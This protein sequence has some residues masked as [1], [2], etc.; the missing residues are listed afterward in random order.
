[1]AEEMEKEATKEKEVV[2]MLEKINGRMED[3]TERIEEIGIE[4]YFDLLK[5]PRRLL[6]TNF[7]VGLAR[8]LGFAV[9]ATILGAIFLM[10]L[11]RL[12]ELNLPVI[13]EFIARVIRIV[14][15]FL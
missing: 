7:I 15:E 11:F 4:D 12:G 13:G 5:S 6:F 10:V 9:G 8:G 2:N 14:Q 1:M 3:I